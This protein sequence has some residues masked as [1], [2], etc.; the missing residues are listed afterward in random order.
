MIRLLKNAPGIASTT[1]ADWGSVAE[2]L[3]SIVAKLRGT[4]LTGDP[5]PDVGIWECSPG[6]WR[7]QIKKA[8]FTYFLAGRC[9]FTADDGQELNI[10][11]GDVLYWPANSTG[12]WDVQETVR[13]VYILL[14]S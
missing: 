5:E 9:T 13:K 6:R 2:P 8:E 11:A 10:G 12:L 4:R 7:R 14:P 1:L 3:G